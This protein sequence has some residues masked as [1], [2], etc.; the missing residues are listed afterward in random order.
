VPST[1]ENVVLT[2]TPTLL[3]TALNNFNTSSDI[4]NYKAHKLL[5][6]MQDF[7]LN[8]MFLKNK[9]ATESDQHVLFDSGINNKD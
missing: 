4:H 2:K 1:V 6:T 9:I 5:K 3:M 8:N 7:T